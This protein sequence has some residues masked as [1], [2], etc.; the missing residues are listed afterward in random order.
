MIVIP[1]CL[2]VLIVFVIP[3]VPLKGYLK[4]MQYR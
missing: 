1:V 2:E 4:S 3:S